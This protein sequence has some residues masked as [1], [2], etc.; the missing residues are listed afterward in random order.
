MTTDTCNCGARLVPSV[1]YD[2]TGPHETLAC[3]EGRA[4]CRTGARPKIR[5]CGQC[6]RVLKSKQMQFCSPAYWRAG[7]RNLRRAENESKPL[8]MFTPIE[9]AS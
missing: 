9:A 5:Y 6:E 7:V 1:R 2:A 4:E 3:F 8:D